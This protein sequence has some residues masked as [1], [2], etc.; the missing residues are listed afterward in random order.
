MPPSIIFSISYFLWDFDIKSE[1]ASEISRVSGELL[2]ANSGLGGAGLGRPPQSS[3][4]LSL[5]L[6]SRELPDTAALAVL[7][8]SFINVK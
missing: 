1:L 8:N 3:H 7:F 4:S 2:T 6:Y 5:E